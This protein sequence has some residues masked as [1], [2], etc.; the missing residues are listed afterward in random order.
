MPVL[1]NTVPVP[2]S[3]N[4]VKLSIKNKSI[5][6]VIIKKRTDISQDD[7]DGFR[8]TFKTYMG[9]ILQNQN[10]YMVFNDAAVREW[11]LIPEPTAVMSSMLSLHL[12]DKDTTTNHT[13][14][15]FM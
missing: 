5:N 12:Q 13:D 4:N 10:L 1:N 8:N 2:I 9:S 11:N 3:I 6:F 14:R 15:N 7:F